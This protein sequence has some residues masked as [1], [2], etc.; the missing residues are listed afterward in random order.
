MNSWLKLPPMARA[1]LVAELGLDLVEVQRQL[2]VGAHLAAD[3]VGDDLLV[4]GSEAVVAVVTVAEALQL[5][6]VE[7]PAPGLA[8]EVAGLDH[9]HED[10]LRA[11]AVHLLA[12]DV[13][14]LVQR[15]QA[16]GQVGVDA[17]GELADEPGAQEQAVADNLGLGR[18]FLQGGD[19]GLGQA[20]I[21]L[22][23]S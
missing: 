4:R 15:F 5:L 20:H 14:H 18:D 23:M 8:P 17:R 6:A 11:R 12:A 1:D 10:L 22:Q 16:Q 13:R 21:I 9:G 7:V 2:A 3:Q 19:I